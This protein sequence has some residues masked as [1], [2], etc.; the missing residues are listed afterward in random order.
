VWIEFNAN[1]AK[2]RARQQQLPLGQ[3]YD[4][5]AVL[6]VDLNASLDAVRDEAHDWAAKRRGNRKGVSIK[7]A[8]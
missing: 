5:A 3:T 8:F 4:E 2:N 7:N 6:C 1:C